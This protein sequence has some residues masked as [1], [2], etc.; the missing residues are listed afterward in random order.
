MSDTLVSRMAMA[1]DAEM[2]R[3]RVAHGW[4]EH[5]HPKFSEWPED[6]RRAATACFIAA[7]KAMR[8]IP[9]PLQMAM[10]VRLIAE[11]DAIDGPVR[12]H[13]DCETLDNWMDRAA[14]LSRRMWSGREAIAAWQGAIDAA[15]KESE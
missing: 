14:G 7:L 8:D 6:E 10:I 2:H 12:K 11:V 3:Q 15:I 13:E 4:P 9:E 5:E 1:F